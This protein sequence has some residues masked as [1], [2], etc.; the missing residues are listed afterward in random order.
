MRSQQAH[1]HLATT[2]PVKGFTLLEA[3]ACVA[4]IGTLAALAVPALSKLLL[5]QRVLTTQH[6][7]IAHLHLARTTAIWRRKKTLI[8]P[9]SNGRQCINASNWSAGW[10]VFLDPDGNGQP[11]QDTDIIRFTAH[12][13]SVHLLV[14]SS[15]GR[16]NVRYLPDGRSAGSN[17]TLSICDSA[18]V[19]QAQIIINNAGRVRSTKPGI[20]QS[21]NV[22]TGVAPSPHAK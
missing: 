8:C 16:S 20:S 21:C 11:D 5:Q 4:V 14:H 1:R 12:P 9:S 19:A 13:T 17:T 22:N 18:G 3:L 7:L 2:L 15:P 10:L 6:A